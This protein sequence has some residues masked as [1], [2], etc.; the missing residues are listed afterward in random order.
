MMPRQRL[1]RGMEEVR[2]AVL[3][4]ARDVDRQLERSTQSLLTGDREL[5]RQLRR[6]D[7]QINERYA[8]LERQVVALIAQHAPTAGDLRAILAALSIGTEL[9]RI[10]DHAAGVAEM[11]LRLSDPTTARIPG[12]MTEMA[13]RARGMVGDAVAAFEHADADAAQA[14]VPEEDVV[15]ALQEETYRALIDGAQAETEVETSVF[16]VLATHHIERVADRATNIAEQAIYAA[17]GRLDELNPTR[18]DA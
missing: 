16:L 11:V 4:L 8:E 9:E 7:A 10:A 18:L 1:A 2:E 12:S 14:L 13:R 6:D 5:A 17:T 3:A 15:D